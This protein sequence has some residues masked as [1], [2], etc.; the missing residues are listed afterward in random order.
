MENRGEERPGVERRAEEGRGDDWR[1]EKRRDLKRRG[2]LSFYVA[3]GPQTP[4]R[5]APFP[6]SLLLPP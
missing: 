4:S 1:V 2:D 6:P 5:F 3:A